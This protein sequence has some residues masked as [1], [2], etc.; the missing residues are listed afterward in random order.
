MAGRTFKKGRWEDGLPIHDQ[1]NQ[2]ESH[3]N[4]GKPGG[5]FWQRAAV[6]TPIIAGIGVGIYRLI[7]RDLFPAIKLPRSSFLDKFAGNLQ[8][9]ASDGA[10]RIA[11]LRGRKETPDP[12]LIRA[13]WEQALQAA[14]PGK[15][16]RRSPLNNEDPLSTIDFFA[17]TNRSYQVDKVIKNFVGQF[18]SLEKHAISTMTS[19]GDIKFSSI[20]APRFMR[21]ELGINEITDP[22]LRESFTNIQQSISNIP[23]ASMNLRIA[24]RPGL[25]G[26]QLMATFTGGKFGNGTTLELPMEL[27]TQPGVVIHGTNQ[28]TKRIVGK[29][30]LVDPVT[31]RI[32]STL[33]HEQFTIRKFQQEILPQLLSDRVK[34][35]SQIHKLVNKFNQDSIASSTWVNNLPTGI[36]PAHDARIAFGADL[37]NLIDQKSLSRLNSET[38]GR[39]LS[40][41]TNALF[42][43]TSGAQLA[44]GV[45]SR[46]NA[47]NYWLGGRSFPWERQPMQ[48]LRRG[49]G[50][51]VNSIEA[52][53]KDSLR[54]KFS[55]MHTEAFTRD[56]GN[57]TDIMANAIYVSEKKH[58][59]F[60]EHAF[61]GVAGGAGLLSKAVSDQLEHDDPLQVKVAKVSDSLKQILEHNKTGEGIYNFKQ[62]LTSLNLTPGEIMGYDMMGNAKHFEEG[63]N[64]MGARL[65]EDDG[66]EFVKF[67]GT[68]TTKPSHPKF[69]G[70]AKMIADVVDQGHIDRLLREKTNLA[71]KGARAVIDM[72]ELKKNRSLHN[73]QMLSALF[74]FTHQNMK[75]QGKTLDST[76]FGKAAQEIASLDPDKAVSSVLGMAREAN[77]TPHQMGLTFGALPEIY[78]DWQERFGGF[79]AEEAQN[80]SSGHAFGVTSLFYGGVPTSGGLGSVEPRFFE[81]LAGKQYGS[82]GNK[83]IDD[84][85]RR[86]ILSNPETVREQ[87]MLRQA[88]E[89]VTHGVKDMEGVSSYHIADMSPS[90]IDEITRKGGIVN[91]GKTVENASSIYVPGSDNSMFMRGFTTQDGYVTSV[92]LKHSYSE[93]LES[94]AG[95]FHGT[96]KRAD[97]EMAMKGL[98][99]ELGTAYSKTITGKGIG[100]A[101]SKVM[102]SLYATVL[103]GTVDELGDLHTAG[104]NKK[105]AMRMFN[106]LEDVHANDPTELI[107]LR[108][109]RERMLAG[110]TVAGLTARDPN[111]GPFSV[112]PQKLKIIHG[113][114]EGYVKLPQQT[115]ILTNEAG[116]EIGRIAL[117][118][119]AGK[120]GDYDEDNVH[121]MLSSS[122]IERDINNHFKIGN[123]KLQEEYII[124]QQLLKVKAPP[125]TGLTLGQE[126]LAGAEKLAISKEKVGPISTPFRDI[127]AAL[128]AANLPQEE[129]MGAMSL[130][131]ALENIPI[132]GKQIAADKIHLLREQM[133]RLG[134]A[135]SRGKGHELGALAE[136]IFASGGSSLA[137]DILTKPQTVFIDKKKMILPA[138]G[139]QKAAENINKV[140]LDFKAPSLSGGMSE[141]TSR[142]IMRGSRSLEAG[143]IGNFLGHSGG[144]L[145]EFKIAGKGFGATIAK[146]RA[147]VMNSLSAAGE[148]FVAHAGK[149]LAIGFGASLAIAAALSKP[150]SNLS[151]GASSPPVSTGRVASTNSDGIKPETV[152]PDSEISGEP[153]APASIL[154]KIVRIDPESARINVRGINKNN[155]NMSAI[156]NEIAR[157]LGRSTTI[158]VNIRDRKTSLNQ[159][160]LDQVIRR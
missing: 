142:A 35:R 96:T 70:G 26:S 98:V 71:F 99:G 25:E 89:S 91:L 118:S 20:R 146:T 124:R 19:P 126:M 120:A 43:S 159:Q 66:R 88:M 84:I 87:S 117:G 1:T 144:L 28:Q 65:H 106:Q 132:S 105:D 73:Q 103:P 72:G 141:S 58:P 24:E 100:L 47:Q 74:E 60:A 143:Q 39:V 10:E 133:E 14:D 68:R 16:I 9:F 36:L 11:E 69:F 59:G 123:L 48:A 57:T 49:Y 158:N 41:E 108:E 150:I 107:A 76:E 55:W 50:P 32:T 160:R 75:R 82:L 113:L 61:G 23:E 44:K 93:L 8:S 155:S 45:V 62:P 137:G 80:I 135:A 104:I 3:A 30:G 85:A 13:A 56:F 40:D 128:T 5:S 145:S 79:S 64:I 37:V 139:I 97:A 63:M 140:M 147:V 129:H 52:R 121:V 109:R 151:P 38:A 17:K 27:S 138:I 6:T 101:R 7:G 86:Q 111:I 110:E 83:M 77:F 33:N 153:S 15:L 122:R 51:S 131:E 90:V 95:V 78:S 12:N 134:T 152:H 102:G 53:A 154:P 125:A 116:A 149:P 92:D 119:M 115:K 130:M 156:S 112:G 2:D 22:L 148:Q 4:A 67:F 29:Y 127:R 34:T 157:R 46:R 21:R 42:P 114:E 18:R 31:N 136:E 54:A 81:T 94:A